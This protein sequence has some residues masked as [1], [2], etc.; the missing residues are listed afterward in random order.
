MN[1]SVFR[2]FLA[3]A[4]LVAT[5]LSSL[6]LDTEAAKDMLGEAK[7]MDFV[8]LSPNSPQP[9]EDTPAMLSMNPASNSPSPAGASKPASVCAKLPIAVKDLNNGDVRILQTASNI[10]S[11]IPAAT[12]ARILASIKADLNDSCVSNKDAAA[13]LA[14]KRTD[15]QIVALY[16]YDWSGFGAVVSIADFGTVNALIYGKKS[17]EEIQQSL[18]NLAAST[19]GLTLPFNNDCL[20]QQVNPEACADLPK[21]LAEVN[22]SDAALT[23]AYAL[24][25]K[26]FEA[27][28]ID[29]NFLI[30]QANVFFQGSGSID[31]N[32]YTDSVV[33]K[34][35]SYDWDGDSRLTDKDAALVSAVW[36]VKDVLNEPLTKENIGRI[37]GEDLNC[38]VVIKNPCLGLDEPS[39][40]PSIGPSGSV[41]PSASVLP[42]LKPNCPCPSDPPCEGGTLVV[43]R[44]AFSSIPPCPSSK[45]EDILT[46]NECFNDCLPIRCRIKECEGVSPS[47]QPSVSVS[48][49]AMPSVMPSMSVSPSAMP[50]MSASPSVM[51]SMSA[52]PS[53]GP[54][55]LP[56][57][58]PNPLGCGEV[59]KPGANSA[60]IAVSTEGPD[61]FNLDAKS[62][63]FLD[64]GAG[65]DVFIYSG[66]SIGALNTFLIGGAGADSLFVPDATAAEA[67]TALKGAGYS[68]ELRKNGFALVTKDGQ[69][70]VFSEVEKIS[71]KDASF[72]ITV[73]AELDAFLAAVTGGGI[74]A[75]AE[76]EQSFENIF[77]N[78]ASC[79]MG[80]FCSPT[81]NICRNPIN[82]IDPSCGGVT[83]STM[84]SMMPSVQPSVSALPSAM[85]SMVPV[86][87]ATCGEVCSDLSDPITMVFPPAPR[88]PNCQ[89]GF[90]C[91]P[92]EK[93][94]RNPKNPTSITCA[95]EDAPSPTPTQIVPTIRPS[96]PIPPIT[97]VG[98]II[99]PVPSERP[100]QLVPAAPALVICPPQGTTQCA[101]GFVPDKS[102]GLFDRNGCLIWESQPCPSRPVTGAPKVDVDCAPQPPIKQCSGGP[103]GARESEVAAANTGLDRNGC[104]IWA[105]PACPVYAPNPNNPSI[106][107]PVI[108]PTINTGV[109]PINT[110]SGGGGVS[111][112]IPAGPP[113]ACAPQPPIK[114]CSGGPI[115]A[116]ESTVAAENTGLGGDGCPIW[117]YPAC[118]IYAPR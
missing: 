118:P 72:D 39:P 101:S 31:K 109:A 42:S 78:T 82:P 9:S 69:K 90:F 76:L 45:P 6:A 50:S 105:Y 35:I 32:I 66:A 77:A 38:P 108:A 19:P 3:L 86:L 81:E 63:G 70:V 79:G 11:S 117:A 103:T 96:Q 49:S 89:I 110:S 74:E 54:S 43:K 28:E 116:R 22:E 17:K 26:E 51:P 56:S 114:Q 83:P 80:L 1:L 5:G 95:S 115:G 62:T 64:G 15:E 24:W 44:Q 55:I 94:C 33:R 71:F 59:C 73:K 30:D 12:D 8:I 29:Y 88:A 84:P 107:Q 98:P 68:I 14:E 2:Y 18:N 60:P 7:D 10:V 25:N 85:P 92:V 37:A 87:D 75:R 113:K 20:I 61:E 97:G 57:M 58:M 53:A 4:L 104:P 100:P 47:A 65:D 112:P 40:S 93:L 46:S 67:I 21:P 27:G 106:I 52:S 23:M 111:Q 16:K 41:N 91:S 99:I 36:W 34:T 102:T 13:C 48:P